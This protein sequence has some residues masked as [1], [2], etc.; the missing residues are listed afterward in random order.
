MKLLVPLLIAAPTLVRGTL[1]LRGRSVARDPHG[2]RIKIGIVFN[3]CYLAA[4]GIAA[5]MLSLN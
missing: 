2:R 4:V 1:A 5:L 3:L